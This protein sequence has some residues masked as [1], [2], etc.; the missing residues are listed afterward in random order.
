MITFR[1]EKKNKTFWPHPMGVCYD[2]IFTF[3]VLCAQ[4]PLIW[5]AAWLQMYFQKR[6]GLTFW[7]NPRVKGVSVGKFFATM[8]SLD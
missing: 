5:Y 1:K 4:F 6:H 3:M 8:V 2:S 7:P